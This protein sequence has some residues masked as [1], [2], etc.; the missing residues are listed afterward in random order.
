MSEKEQCSTCR[1]FKDIGPREDYGFC[2]RFPPSVRGTD[3]NEIFHHIGSWVD[4]WCGEWEP[5]QLIMERTDH[6]KAM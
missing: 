5:V 2:R 1:F 3:N 4:A 6:G